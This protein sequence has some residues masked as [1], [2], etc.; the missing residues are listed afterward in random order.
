MSALV[1]AKGLPLAVALGPGNCS[2][3]RMAPATLGGWRPRRLAA[4]RGYDAAWLRKYLRSRRVRPCIPSIKTRKRQAR[5]DWKLY[6]RRNLVERFF[7]RMK[8]WAALAFRREKNDA[9]FFSLLTLFCVVDW[10]KK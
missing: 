8:G 6:A 3:V 4:D 2:E 7:C 9:S 1:D 5:P 10:I